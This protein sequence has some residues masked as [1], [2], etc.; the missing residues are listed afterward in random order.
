MLN[1]L[2]KMYDSDDAVAVM[3]R[4]M[5]TIACVARNSASLKPASPNQR[6]RRRPARPRA[7]GSA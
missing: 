3:E 5:E 4:V 7:P 1:Q 6:K 2:G